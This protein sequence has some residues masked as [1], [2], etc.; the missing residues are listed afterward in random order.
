VGVAV[1]QKWQQNPWAWA[2]WKWVAPG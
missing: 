2:E 1:R